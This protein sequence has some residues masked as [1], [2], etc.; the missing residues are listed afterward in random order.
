MKYRMFF[1]FTLFVC[2]LSGISH[3]Q[4][5]ISGTIRDCEGNGIA[6]VELLGW[7]GPNPHTDSQGYYYGVVK[8]IFALIFNTKPFK[9]THYSQ[10]T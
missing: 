4:I 9:C 3:A 8:G 10:N 5:I 1:I 2:I 7:P 6:G